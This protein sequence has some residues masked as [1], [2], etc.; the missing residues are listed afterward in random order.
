MVEIHNTIA[1]MISLYALLVGLWGLFNFIRRQPPDASYNGALAIAVGLFVL[2]GIVGMA[3]VLAGM[4]PARWVHFLYG[5]TI[6]LT[7]PAIFAFTRGSNSTR[8]SLLYGI[9]MLFIWGLAER[10]QFTGR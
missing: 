7:I 10:A 8:E 1:N 4:A 9:G 2:E 3:L 6:V 5:I